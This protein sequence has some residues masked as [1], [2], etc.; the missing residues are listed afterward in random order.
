MDNDNR[1]SFDAKETF[2]DAASGGG[3]IVH[4]LTHQD[5]DLAVVFSREALA[6]LRLHIESALAQEAARGQDQ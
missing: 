1:W 2:V 4:I 5:S 3:F 6:H